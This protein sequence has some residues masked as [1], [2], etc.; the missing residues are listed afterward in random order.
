M[1]GADSSFTSTINNIYDEKYICEW[2]LRTKQTLALRYVT[3]VVCAATR[4]E[5]IDWKA[6]YDGMVQ[7]VNKQ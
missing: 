7:N 5:M 3:I 1:V 6:E 2:L 4:S